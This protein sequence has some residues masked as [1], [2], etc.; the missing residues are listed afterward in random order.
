M[1]N[2]LIKPYGNLGKATD[3]HGFGGDLKRNIPY[4][5]IGKPRWRITQLGPKVAAAAG[6]SHTQNVFSGACFC[7]RAHD[8]GGPRN[9]QCFLFVR[10]HRPWPKAHKAH[11]SAHEKKHCHFRAP[12]G[13]CARRTVN[14]ASN[15]RALS[16][17]YT[18]HNLGLR[19]LCC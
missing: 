11:P 18:V 8:P 1:Q 6:A 2:H 15:S 17:C 5:S 14:W 16:R 3:L 10:R 4:K 12:A 13:A 7:L 19:R 9:R